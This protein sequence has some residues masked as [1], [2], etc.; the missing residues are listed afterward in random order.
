MPFGLQR[1]NKAIYEKSAN[2][3]PFSINMGRSVGSLCATSCLWMCA[4]RVTVFGPLEHEASG[5]QKRE[6]IFCILMR[7]S[8]AQGRKRHQHFHFFSIFHS[9]SQMVAQSKA[10]SHK[11]TCCCFLRVVLL[12]RVSCQQHFP[13]KAE[14][15]GLIVGNHPESFIIQKVMAAAH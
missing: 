6:H 1:Q 7:N 8:I 14:R 2:F 5:R 3:L 10:F 13:Y 4:V 9:M 15:V 12:N 11:P